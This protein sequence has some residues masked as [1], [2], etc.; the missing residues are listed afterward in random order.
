MNLFR[1]LTKTDYQDVLRAIGYLC[2]ERGLRHVRM[3]EHEDGLLIQ[4]L[5]IVNGQVGTVFETIRL[6]DHDL[7]ALLRKAYHRRSNVTT[8]VHALPK[9][10]T[11]PNTGLRG[12]LPP[13]PLA[14]ARQG[15][16]R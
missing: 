13:T 2:D 11:V 9:P 1:G 10:P 3:I 16:G 5:P 7:E 15:R 8:P 6:T 12:L 4:G 14:P